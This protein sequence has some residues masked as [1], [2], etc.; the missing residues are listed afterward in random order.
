MATACFTGHRQLNGQ[1]YNRN[2]PSTEW[3]MLKNYLN[4]VLMGL[5]TQHNCIHTGPATQ[6][7]CVNHFISGLA[8]GVDMLAAECVAHTRTLVKTPIILT[9]AMPFPSQPS[10]WPQHSQDHFQYICAL[11]NEVV[12]VSPDPYHPSKMQIR[13]EWMVDRSNYVIAIW[14]GI[15]KGGTWNCISYTRSAGKPV[16]W[17]ELNGTQWRNSWI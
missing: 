5:M 4:T 15:E 10:K 16:L 13:N 12:T 1:Y 11:C 6:C 17:I 3:V 14:N 9:G 2:N 8:I 7:N